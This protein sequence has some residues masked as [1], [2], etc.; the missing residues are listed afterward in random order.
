MLSERKLESQSAILADI[1]AQL[2]QAVMGEKRP[3]DRFLAAHLRAHHELGSRDR[4]LISEVVFAVFRWWG[5]LRPLVPAAFT[6]YPSTVTDHAEELPETTG[7]VRIG[8]Q[9]VKVSAGSIP[10]WYRLFLAIGLLENM[11]FPEIMD[12]WLKQTALGT[13]LAEIERLPADWIARIVTVYHLLQ[14][15]PPFFKPEQLVPDW[16]PAAFSA[17]I[18]AHD[19]IGWFQRRPP[20]WLRLQGNADPIIAEL[21]AAGLY[22]ETHPKLTNAV[23][24]G[25]T[26]VNL[27]TLPAY[28][29]G[30]VEVQ[31]L[32]S[33][34]V[35][36]VCAPQPGERWWDACAGAGGKSLL[37]AQLMQGKGTV[38]ATDI[39]EYKLEDLRR[40]ARRGGFFNITGRAWD[41]RP[42]PARK[43]TYDGVLTDA[44][45]SCSGTWR[46]NPGGRWSLEA[47][48]LNDLTRLQAEILRNAASGV[49]PGGILVY[50][51]C[52]VF[53]RENRDVVE[54]FLRDQPQFRL[55]P[56]PHPLTG[57]ATD[58]MVQILPGDGDCDAMFAARFRRA[59][60]P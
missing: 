25:N 14:V 21:T 48:E 45:C 50:A 2:L 27:Y 1:V 20:L 4:R 42:L 54:G 32:G 9:A 17:G 16:A 5:W 46:R 19:L 53:Q 59:A 10:A 8:P 41:G 55:E 44:P 33:Q 12:F 24:T 38:V 31:D 3:A 6:I 40:R 37:L 35:G 23:R 28:R 18:S 49:K 57:Q 52:S 36:L 22:P 26:R 39:R 47:G 13:S 29:E 56:C 11:D 58:G 34:A 60:V 43:A 51:T 15:P 30:R 7:A